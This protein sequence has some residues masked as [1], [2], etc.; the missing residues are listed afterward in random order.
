MN[1]N[2]A[3]GDNGASDLDNGQSAVIKGYHHV[4]YKS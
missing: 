3:G 1:V 4:K 2:V